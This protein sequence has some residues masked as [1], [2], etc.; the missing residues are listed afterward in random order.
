MRFATIIYHYSTEAVPCFEK[1]RVFLSNVMTLVLIL[2]QNL[3]H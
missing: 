2:N 1:N 3:N